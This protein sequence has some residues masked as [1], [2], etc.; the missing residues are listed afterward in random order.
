MAAR[1]RPRPKRETGEKPWRPTPER[2]AVLTRILTAFGGTQALAEIEAGMSPGALTHALQRGEAREAEGRVDSWEA[3]LVQV[4][5]RAREEH[6]RKLVDV[7]VSAAENG[8]EQTITEVRNGPGGTTTIV[9][10]L[11]EFHPELALEVLARRYPEEWGRKDHA[12]VRVDVDLEARLTQV[13]EMILSL[14]Q[15]PRIVEYLEAR[16]VR[17]LPSGANGGADGCD[18]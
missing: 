9:R 16:M 17:R 15:D 6:K 1:H 14:Q 7:V 18:G 5:R 13:R 12:Q 11:K 8:T 2:I 4:V 10:S 3:K